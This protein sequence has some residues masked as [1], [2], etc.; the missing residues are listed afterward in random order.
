MKLLIADNFFYQQHALFLRFAHW[1]HFAI[2]KNKTSASVSLLCVIAYCVGISTSWKTR[3]TSAPSTTHTTP[4]ATVSSAW[5]RWQQQQAFFPFYCLYWLVT[6]LLLAFLTSVSF[7]DWIRIQSG[8]VD[9]DLDAESGSGS[10]RAKMTHKNR[11]KLRNFMFWSAWCSLLRAEGFSCS[12]E[13]LYRGV[14]ISKWQFL[15]K[16]ISNLFSAVK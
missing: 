11:K 4:A 16:T 12:L 5:I 7:P 15:I 8:T 1:L 14:G 9:P 2:S 13:V 3:M 10:R 6:K